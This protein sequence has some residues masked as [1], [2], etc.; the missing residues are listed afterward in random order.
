M[1][2]STIAIDLDFDNDDD[3]VNCTDHH[4]K[5][6]CNDVT[7]SK[8]HPSLNCLK[9]K[10]LLQIATQNL[11][12]TKKEGHLAQLGT[13]IIAQMLMYDQSTRLTA[14]AAASLLKQLDN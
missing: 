13:R 1:N 9:E 7:C 4:A 10:I 5:L 12:K 3:S 6:L 11:T 2:A 8:L 14:Y